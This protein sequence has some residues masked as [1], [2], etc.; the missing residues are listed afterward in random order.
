MRPSNINRRSLSSNIQSFSYGRSL[1]LLVYGSP[2]QTA[3]YS[4]G[5]ARAIPCRHLGLLP[6]TLD[7]YKRS[8]ANLI[9]NVSEREVSCTVLVH[10]LRLSRSSQSRDTIVPAPE[11]A[12]AAVMSTTASHQVENVV[13]LRDRARYF[14][15]AGK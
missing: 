1:C 10:W 15:G 7:W 13:S 9:L 2:A 8:T 6:S 14:L 11:G 4:W 3:Q 5:L 12:R